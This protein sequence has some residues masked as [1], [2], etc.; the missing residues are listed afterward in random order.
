[1]GFS[2]CC[3]CDEPSTAQRAARRG[4]KK[5]VTSI[6]CNDDYLLGFDFGDDLVLLKDYRDYA[7]W[8]TRVY[9]YMR[10]YLWT[11]LRIKNLQKIESL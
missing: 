11:I 10:I 8:V 1:M 4:C 6:L 3:P 7:D 5:D 9:K 2:P